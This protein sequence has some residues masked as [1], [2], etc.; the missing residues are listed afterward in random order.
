[1]SLNFGRTQLSIPGPSVIPDRVL[2]AMHRPSPNIYEG[3]LIELTHSLYPDLKTVAQTS[4]NAAIY[5]ANGHGA[6]EAALRNTINPGEKVLVLSTGFFAA[7]WGA[8]AQA[9]GIEVEVAEFG[10]QSDADA[11]RVKDILAKDTERKLKAVMVVLADTAS[12]VRNDIVKLREAIDSSGHDALFMVDCIASLGCDRFRMDDWGVDVTVTGSQK[13]LMTPAGLS[14]VFFNGKAAAARKGTRPGRYFDWIPRT[15]PE[16]FYHLFS[17]TAPTHH[18]FAL[19]EALNMLVH[20]EGVEAAWSRHE[21]IA[22]AYWAAIEA[23][24]TG[25]AMHHN[26]EDHAKRTV[27]VSAITT[28]DGE[29]PKIRQWCEKEGGVTLGIPLGYAEAEWGEHFRIGHMGHQN[30]AMTMGVLGAIDTALKAQNIPHGDGA[31]STAAHI[32][33]SHAGDSATT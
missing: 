4:G 22:K 1:M 21:T 33:A 29:A 12:S 30:L 9:M 10:M 2:A 13:G 5:I 24:G 16:V 32:L 14:F 28:G 27:A 11:G 15:E 23:W 25:G 7:T 6:W 3:D 17:G 19:R 20:E 18:L 26:I 8:L 31:L